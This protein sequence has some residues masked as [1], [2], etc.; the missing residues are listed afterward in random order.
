[1]EIKWLNEASQQFLEGGY[2]LPGQTVE[3]RL[4]VIGDR[5]EEILGIEGFSTKVQQ[6][7]A[8]GWISLSTPIWSNFGTDRGLPISCF[9]SVAPDSVDGILS[10]VAEIGTMSKHGGGTGLYMGDVRPRGAEIK[11][12]GTS[13]GT[14][15]FLELFQTCTGVISQGSTRRGYLA[16][17]IDIFHKDIEE[18]LNI[19]SEG[20]TIQHLTWGVCVPTNWLNEMKGGDEQKRKIWA[21]VIQKRFE[22]GLPYI[23]FTD[24]ANNGESTP[25]VYKGKDLIKASNLC[26]V[27]SDVAVTSKGLIKVQDLYESGDALTLF[28]N[29]KV[30]KASPMKLVEKN[31]DVY[32]VTL[33]NGMSH[34]ITDYHKLKIY[35]DYH[36]PYIMKEC[37]ELVVGDKVCVQTKK[38]LFGD[39]EMEDEAYLLGLYQ[40][41]GTQYEDIIMLDVWENDFDLL[42]DIQ[43]KFS[44]IHYK[45]NCNRYDI[46]NSEGT[47]V[48]SRERKPSVFND[49]TVNQSTVKK[50][51]L[52]S[53][54]L[55]KSLNFKKGVVPDWILKGTEKTQWSYIKGLL[56]ADGTVYVGSSSNIQLAYYDI[57]KSFLEQ[58]QLVFNNLG[59]NSKIKISRSSG[60]NSLPDGRG[61][62]KMYQTKD[63]WRLYV[64]NMP[65]CLEIEKNTGFLSR[66]GIVLDNRDYRNNTK[67][68]FKITSIEYVG[69]EDVYCTTVDSQ[70]HLWV[71]NGFITSN[72]SEIFL[73]SNDE[74]SF[75]CDLSSL[76][77]LYY[78]EWKDTDCVEVVTFLLDAAMTEFIEKA[79]NIKFFDRAVNFSKRHRA[80]GI[81][82]LGYHSF[83]Q[84]KM[85]AFESLEARNWNIQIQKTIKEQAYAASEK[86]AQMFGE[87]E[88]TKGTGR[89]NSTLIAIAPTTSSAFI[90]GQVSQSIECWNSNYFIKD[91]AKGKFVIKNRYLEALIESLGKNTP[92]VWDSIKK[93]HGSVLH[94]DFLSDQ[95]KRV[96]LTGKE[97][98]QDEVILQ[99]SHRQKHIDQGQSL[100]LYID[101][102]K[103]AKDVNA[104]MLKAHDLGLK[105]LYYQHNFNAAQLLTKELLTCA[106]CE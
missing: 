76:N 106:S 4:K 23:F 92:D 42:E 62:Y 30:V 54:T 10:T 52:A 16:A 49:C 60:E 13:N 70:E 56:E 7:I 101:S 69:K 22:T 3:E 5:A 66:K 29:E 36:K 82:R 85:V 102:S 65:D 100:N 12:N 97:V 2:L 53:K 31:K 93:N 1:M 99:A 17:Y 64:S 79:S 98:S 11:G 48:G 87:C 8:N 50:K 89:R 43:K 83:L 15:S 81:G 105:S 59:L 68:S 19:R 58:L 14:K 32:R 38:G 103:T 41:D 39:I 78:E 9:S 45:Y 104:L 21:K 96:F 51:R 20:D 40:S 73:P 80:L 75:V 57:D 26:V 37:K 27:G 28:D 18:W 77:D 24:N 67:K 55:N 91:L 84:S 74:E 72:C 71:C 47:I 6:Y 25:E 95:Q 94:L 46:K 86:L 35:Q 90:L 34:T 61:G 88:V 44:K 33:E 63:C